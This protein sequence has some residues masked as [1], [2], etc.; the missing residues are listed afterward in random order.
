MSE[1]TRQPRGK[2]MHTLSIGDSVLEPGGYT[3][4]LSKLDFLN[5]LEVKLAK[6]FNR[7]TSDLVRLGRSIYAAFREI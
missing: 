4:F 6:L 3:M 2:D 5:W 7:H 1:S